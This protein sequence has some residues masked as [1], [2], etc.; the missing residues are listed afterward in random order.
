MDDYE[1]NIL[2]VETDDEK[3]LDISKAEYTN[4]C[5]D[6]PIKT[7]IKIIR[8]LN[9]DTDIKEWIENELNNLTQRFHKIDIDALS[10]Y[11]IKAHIALGKPYSIDEILQITGASKHKK[12]ILSLI[13]GTDL[14]RSAVNETDMIIPLLITRP[15]SFVPEIVNNFYLKYDIAKE[16]IP[17]LTLN[18][19]YF[20]EI[21]YKS[22][23]S[24]A[25]NSPRCCAC[26]FIYFYIKRFVKLVGKN[27]VNIT[28]SFFK[29]MQF[30]S[31]TLTKMGHT[32]DFD[33]CLEAITETVNIFIEESKD[34]DDINRLTKY[35]FFKKN[36]FEKDDM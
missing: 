24:L 10:A 27:N 33:L 8:S 18:I 35:N 20:S 36:T 25:N 4:E 14:K 12:R 30:G 17:D 2:M 34:S 31:L 29:K 6:Y 22:D 23:Q 16:D 1:G 28:K 11:F 32:K 3:G 21:I 7:H 13:Q 9:F 26:A 5:N 15:M 19:I